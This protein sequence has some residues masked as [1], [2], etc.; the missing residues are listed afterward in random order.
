MAGE[1]ATEICQPL[2]PLGEH[3]ARLPLDVHLAKMLVYATVFQCIDPILT[4]VAALSNRS[5]FLRPYGES[6]AADQAKRAF[7]TGKF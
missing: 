4:I 6:I 2:T 3:L 5:I 1:E 7:A